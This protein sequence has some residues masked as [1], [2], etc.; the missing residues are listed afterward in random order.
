MISD[1]GIFSLEPLKELKTIGLAWNKRISDDSIISLATSARSI[2]S[3]N[4][5]CCTMLSD[6]SCEVRPHAQH[7][8]MHVPSMS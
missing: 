2:V 5:Q 7:L 1:S 8:L 6:L 3:I 4:L